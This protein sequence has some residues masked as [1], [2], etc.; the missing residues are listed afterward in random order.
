VGN[1]TIYKNFQILVT[2]VEKISTYRDAR[3]LCVGGGR[4]DH[5][6][7]ILEEKN[8]A[9]NF[10]FIDYV[11]D[12]ELAALYRNA[13]ALVFPS[14][15]EGFGFPVLE[16]MVHECPVVC[17]G[18]SSLPEVGDDAAFYFEPDSIESLDDA[19]KRLSKA[20]R[21]KVIRKGKQNTDRFSWERS[22]KNLVKI[23]KD[24]IST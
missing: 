1:R 17:S 5:T 4:A 12:D 18:V 20:D 15:Y 9:K 6:I 16:A 2:L 24:I 23:Y 10:I 8:Q 3:F 14:K 21:G 13:L 7:N 19:L 11:S 22:T